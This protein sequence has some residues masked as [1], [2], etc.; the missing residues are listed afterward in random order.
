MSLPASFF[1]V[2]KYLLLSSHFEKVVS[3]K[4][5]FKMMGKKHIFLVQTFE[6]HVHSIR[7]MC[8]QTFKTQYKTEYCVLQ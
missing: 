6:I 3:I 8:P 1:L 4:R 7:K 2:K 5:N